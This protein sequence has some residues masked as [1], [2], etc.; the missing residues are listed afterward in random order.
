MYADQLVSFFFCTQ[1]KIATYFQGPTVPAA[2]KKRKMAA[3]RKVEYDDSDPNYAMWMPPQS[4]FPFGFPCGPHTGENSSMYPLVS[5]Q[6]LMVFFCF[7]LFNKDV[8]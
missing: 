3:P 5:S 4:E 8:I 1:T 7:V 2:K 6:L